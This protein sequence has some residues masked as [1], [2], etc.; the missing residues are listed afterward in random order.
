MI[1]SFN[2]RGL[3]SFYDRGTTRYLSADQVS[4]IRQ[5]LN[6]LDVA[7]APN[8]L[9]IASLRLHRLKGK[10][11]GFGSVSVSGNW[12]I[13]FRFES[14]DAYDVELIDYH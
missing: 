12:R 14:G 9:N 1:R 2:H 4:R 10:F 3:K 7:I 6:L 8:D 5:I 13:I 11:N